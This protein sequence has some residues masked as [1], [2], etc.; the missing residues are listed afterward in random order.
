[1]L[2]VAVKPPPVAMTGIVYVRAG[3]SIGPLWL[4][5]TARVTASSPVRIGELNWVF[6]KGD[7]LVALTV[8]LSGKSGGSSSR[9]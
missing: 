5:A 4:L 6:R 3:R 1:M 8:T 2:V 7:G 9:E